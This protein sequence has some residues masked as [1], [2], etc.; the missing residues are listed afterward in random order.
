MDFESYSGFAQR[1]NMLIGIIICA[2]FTSIL[3]LILP[4]G[5]IFLADIYLVI[6]C[7]IGLYFTF[8]NKKE[9]QSYIKTGIIV[10]LIGSVLSLISIGILYSL[11]Y[12]PDFILFLQ[13]I[14]FL[15]LNNGIMYVV[16]GIILGY[17]FGYLYRNKEA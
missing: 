3:F 7:C 2:L 1:Y 4:Y 5:Y 15:F 14:L 13:L 9:S 11:V 6:G 16:V 12:G 10:G 8:K 17:I